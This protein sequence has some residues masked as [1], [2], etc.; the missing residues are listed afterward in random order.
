MKHKPKKVLKYCII[1]IED[2]DICEKCE[3]FA[4]A[5]DKIAIWRDND[6][7]FAR[8]GW[9]GKPGNYKIQPMMVD[10]AMDKS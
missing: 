8:Q 6:E 4:D 5:Q 7:R 10:C 1:R 2:N 9:I 3:T